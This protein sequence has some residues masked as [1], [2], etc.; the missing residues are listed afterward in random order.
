MTKNKAASSRKAGSVDM[1]VGIRIRTARLAAK[2]SQ[3][4][5]GKSLGVTFQQ[6]QKYEKGMNR[7]SPGRLVDLSKILGK[8]T[9]YFLEEPNYKP[10]SVGEKLAQ[11][12]ATRVGH[13]L[14]ETV[15][16]LAPAMQQ[17]VLD[18]ARKLS[19]QKEAA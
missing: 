10:N 13:Q 1:T 12:A 11:F 7:V 5:L 15:M 18:I 17:T 4:E 14:L 9:T 16:P 6:V 2:L 8:P 3:E 19:V